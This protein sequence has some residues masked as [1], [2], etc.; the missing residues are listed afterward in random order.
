MLYNNRRSEIFILLVINQH[1]CLVFP[2]VQ[3]KH[4][5]APSP[6]AVSIS[7]CYLPQAPSHPAHAQAL[8]AMRVCRRRRRRGA[9][10]IS[11]LHLRRRPRTALLADARGVEVEV[12]GLAHRMFE[13]MPCR[14]RSN[15]CYVS[16]FA[17]S[18]SIELGC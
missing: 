18:R 4:K 12:E 2:S 7:T 8:D 6:S 17:G 13:E 5:L 3:H 14:Y 10:R 1:V 11:A 15:F 16:I 9:A